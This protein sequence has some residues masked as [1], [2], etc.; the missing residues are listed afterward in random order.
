MFRRKYRD[1]CFFHEVWRQVNW[2]KALRQNL[3]GSAAND[4]LE[5]LESSWK[6]RSGKQ[7]NVVLYGKLWR[8]DLHEWYSAQFQVKFS[9]SGQ[10]DQVIIHFQGIFN[11]VVT[12]VPNYCSR[13]EGI[14]PLMDIFNSKSKQFGV[15][16]QI[17]W[18]AAFQNKTTHTSCQRQVTFPSTG[19]ILPSFTLLYSSC[20]CSE[21]SQ[22]P[23]WLR[24]QSQILSCATLIHP[25][26]V[27]RKKRLLG[28]WI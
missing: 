13:E 7:W 23:L 18:A 11:W 10:K 22:W 20:P 17:Y 1:H 3:F 14:Y 4:F 6:W 9:Y 21:L 28:I 27:L 8:E 25:K 19:L 24:R 5:I 16:Q 26:K 2:L 12:S 15:A